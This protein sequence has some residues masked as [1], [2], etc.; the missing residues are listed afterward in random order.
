MTDENARSSLEFLLQKY[1]GVEGNTVELGVWRGATARVFRGLLP[2]AQHWCIDTFEGVP[3]DTLAP[4]EKHLAGTFADTATSFLDLSD[5]GLHVVQGEFPRVDLPDQRYL[6]AFYD[7]DTGQGVH[8]FLDYFWAR[9]EI[10]GVL[11]FHDFGD[12]R[13]PGVTR[14]LRPL[15]DSGFLWALP[16]LVYT[17]K[18]PE[19]CL[20]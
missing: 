7:A 13:F 20:P 3:A 15:W 10:G 16:G 8:D 2:Q 14:A 18:P 4:D 1:V 5:S 6:A 12:A 17:I 11:A 9:M 19:L